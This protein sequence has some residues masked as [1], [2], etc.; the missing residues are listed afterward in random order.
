MLKKRLLIAAPFLWAAI[1]F[2]LHV[3]PIKPHREPQFKIPHLDK[4]VHFVMFFTLAFLIYRALVVARNSLKPLAKQIAFI[5]LFCLSYGALM[6]FLQGT[7][8]NE[9]DSDVFDWFA[10]AAGTFTG[11][12]LASTSFLA[13]LFGLQVRK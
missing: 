4:A 12:W 5:A 3:I 7:Y 9:R 8:F 11:L 6:E 2:L 10:D 13:T 1:V